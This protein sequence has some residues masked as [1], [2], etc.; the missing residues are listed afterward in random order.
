MTTSSS[1][2]AHPLFSLY[3][4]STWTS[5]ERERMDLALRCHSFSRIPVRSSRTPAT[6]QILQPVRPN[7]V[8]G[9]SAYPSSCIYVRYLW[10]RGST[11]STNASVRGPASEEGKRAIFRNPSWGNGCQWPVDHHLRNNV[12]RKQIMFFSPIKKTT[13]EATQQRRSETDNGEDPASCAISRYG[14]M[15]EIF[16]FLFNDGGERNEA[17][18][19]RPGL[20]RLALFLTCQRPNLM[21]KG[22]G[23]GCYFRHLFK[24]NEHDLLV[25]CLVV[26]TDCNQID[27]L[28]RRVMIACRPTWAYLSLACIPNLGLGKSITQP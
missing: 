6:D 20:G 2:D 8:A 5:L 21:H 15:H 13:R 27:V 4:R 3:G 7:M 17:R 16:M 1:H 22:V 26:A 28:T 11:K 25:M 19:P 23:E 24:S 14:H 18:Y 10:C 12:I 9:R